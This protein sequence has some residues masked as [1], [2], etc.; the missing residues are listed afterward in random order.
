MQKD[1]IL[2]SHG[3]GGT[4][5]HQLIQDLFIKKFSNPILNQLTDSANLDSSLCFTTDSYVVNP[6]F[7]PGGDIGKL[8]ICG[9][10]NDLA[11]MGAVPKYISCGFIIE[12]GLDYNVL[13]KI[14][15]SMA[16]IAKA[17]N[18][19]IVTGD[20][21]VV[22]KGSADKLFINTSGIGTTKFSLNKGSIKPGDKICINGPIG[23]HGL[24]VLLARGDLGI[25]A[26]MESDCAPLTREIQNNLKN[27]PGIKF[28]RDPTRGGL[29]TTLNEIVEGMN[30][31][32]LIDEEQVPVKKEVKAVCELL[33][34]DPLYLANE[35]KVITV[36]SNAFPNIIGEVV[37]EPKGRVIMKTKIGGT[38]IVDM[39][40]G[41]QLPR[42]C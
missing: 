29:A 36:S 11:V 10:I 26:K 4:L 13:D 18:V 39:P 40:V 15:E 23:E 16:R 24:A 9:T 20:L 5:M 1:K 12:E 35:G 6:L 17:E 34:F 3:G 30:F 22:E 8:A 37:S 38:R 7:F 32:I 25:R 14:T 42:I 28:M 27:N 2:L 33:G 41:D 19:S 21:K 31:G